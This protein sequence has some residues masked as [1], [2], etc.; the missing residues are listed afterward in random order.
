VDKRKDEGRG[1]WR[2]RQCAKKET[3]MPMADF[4]R[5]TSGWVYNRLVDRGRIYAHRDVNSVSEMSTLLANKKRE[6]IISKTPGC[7]GECDGQ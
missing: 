2:D 1:V 7:V 3:A 6:S 4:S 5:W